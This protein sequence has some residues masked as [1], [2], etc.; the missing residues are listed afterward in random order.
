[1]KRIYPYERKIYYYETDQMGI[2]HHSNYIKIF[3]EARMDFIAQA[4]LSYADIEAA[5]VM[6]PILSVECNYLKPLRYNEK[7]AV[8]SE[9]TKCNGVI[10]EIEYTIKS[11]ETGIICITGKSRQCFTDMEMKPIRTRRTHVEIY[12]VF[13]DYTGYKIPEN[14]EE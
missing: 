12:R 1:M 9:I 2:V 14:K 11:L 10:V 13:S 3:E 7:F 8:Y 6:M 5:G 4:G